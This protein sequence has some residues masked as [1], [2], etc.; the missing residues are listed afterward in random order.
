V[1][2]FVYIRRADKNWTQFS[3]CRH[4]GIAIAECV[5]STATVYRIRDAV[6]VRINYSY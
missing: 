1:L 6:V 2:L 3:S 4:N 5:V